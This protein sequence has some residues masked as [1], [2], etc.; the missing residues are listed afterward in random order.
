M[1]YFLIFFYPN[2]DFSKSK[3]VVNMNSS[4]NYFLNIKI[5]L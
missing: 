3:P 4:Y 5:A 2:D 1:V